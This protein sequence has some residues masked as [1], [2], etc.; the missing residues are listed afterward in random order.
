MY[1][2]TYIH[3]HIYTHIRRLCAGFGLADERRRWFR[4]QEAQKEEKE[5][6]QVGGM[7]LCLQYP[8]VD[9]RSMIKAPAC[10]CLPICKDSQFDSLAAPS[11]FVRTCCHVLFHKLVSAYNHPFFHSSAWYFHIVVVVVRLTNI[12]VESRFH[13][14][15]LR[16]ILDDILLACVGI[17]ESDA[18]LTTQHPL[19]IKM[20]IPPKQGAS[21]DTPTVKLVFS[22]LPRLQVITVKHS[23]STGGEDP[24]LLQVHFCF[25]FCVLSV[26]C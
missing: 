20:S 5:W 1:T 22:F 19:Q 11:H 16:H 12:V 7:T 23:L 3:T 24:T 15:S 4:C 9:W 14:S 17:R 26:Q 13:S 21:S 2:H 10:S 8:T 18:A 6:R 25:S